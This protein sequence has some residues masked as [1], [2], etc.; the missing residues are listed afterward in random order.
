MNCA[1]AFDGFRI[2]ETQRR[3]SLG[4][5]ISTLFQLSSDDVVHS[6]T[7]P[8]LGFKM[9]CIPG[10][11][12]EVGVV[13]FSSGIFHGHC[14]EICGAGHSIMPIEVVRFY[15]GSLKKTLV[16]GTRDGVFPL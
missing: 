4:S 3:V 14:A 13:V 15:R 12:T 7:V 5:G 6:F 8:S 9:D 10:K 11:M 1:A 16:L 2:L